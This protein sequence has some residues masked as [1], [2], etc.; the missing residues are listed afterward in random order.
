MV[1]LVCGSWHHLACDPQKVWTIGAFG[2]G[3]RTRTE[4]RKS[5][6]RIWYHQLTANDYLVLSLL[7]SH[8]M[9]QTV[10]NKFRDVN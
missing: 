4:L 1:I 8:A 10:S 5:S 3:I 6:A 7:D 9:L 2:L